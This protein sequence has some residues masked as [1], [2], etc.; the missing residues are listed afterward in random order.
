MAEADALYLN[1]NPHTRAR[2]IVE[3]RTDRENAALRAKYPNY[4]SSDRRP[5]CTVCARS[6]RRRKWT[7]CS[8]HV[9]S[10]KR[11]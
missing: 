6:S 11:F 3:T 1:D 2:N 4:E 10:Q 7:K 8:V 9:I 5:S